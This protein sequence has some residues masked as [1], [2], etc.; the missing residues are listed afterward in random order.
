MCLCGVDIE[1]VSWNSGKVRRESYERREKKERKRERRVRWKTKREKE[2]ERERERERKKE[3]GWQLTRKEI[4][5]AC[6]SFSI[7][8]NN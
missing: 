2:R 5:S 6:T 1:G 3:E 8:Y 7:V 4:I